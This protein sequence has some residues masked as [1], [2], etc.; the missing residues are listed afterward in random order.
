VLSYYGDTMTSALGLPRK[1]PR[2]VARVVCFMKVKA[3]PVPADDPAGAIAVSDMLPE[4]LEHLEK[5]LSEVYIPLL[6]N[7]VNQ[8]G[9]GEVAAKEIMDRLHAFLANVSITVGQ[10]RG[11]TCL[12]LP[13]LDAATAAHITTKDRI[14]LLE[15]AVITWTKQIKASAGRVDGGGRGGGGTGPRALPPRACRPARRL[16]GRAW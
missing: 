5:V 12:P 13:P 16:H 3:E 14:H 11:E 2:G 1:V 10:T 6:S 15:G 8:E 9:W 7:P 4:P